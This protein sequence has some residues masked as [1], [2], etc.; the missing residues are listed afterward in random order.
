MRPP[1]HTQWSDALLDAQRQVGDPPADAVVDALFAGGATVA[2]AAN[3]LLRDLVDN[4]DIPD[5]ALPAQVRDYFLADRLPPWADHDAIDLAGR[6]FHREAPRLVLLLHTAALPYCYAARRGVQV[7]ARTDRIGSDTQ[8]RILET[9]QFV[10]DV[11]APGGLRRDPD[12]FGAGV[13]SAQKVRLMHAAIRR[14]L[15]LDPTW[16]PEWGV[17]I[18]QEDLA[19]TLLSFSA[20][21]LRGLQGLG[22]DLSDDE[23]AAYLHAWNV[24]GAL[25]GV[26]PA[27]MAPDYP[28]ALRLTDAIARRHHESCPEGQAMTRALLR[29]MEYNLPGT[30]LDGLPALLLHECAGPRVAALLGVERPALHGRWVAA[31]RAMGRLGDDLRDQ[32]ALLR[33]AAELTGRLTLQGLLLAYRGPKRAPFRLPHALREA[34]GLL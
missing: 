10:L 23:I 3:V 15:R 27:L 14:F 33:R 30:A 25:L 22:V 21:S 29:Y 32:S 12:R 16:D 9:A 28:A 34:H 5:A 7:L 24:V 19:G 17:P 1:T 2:Y 20:L 18:N 31:L 26:D 8:R 6:L 11:L 4:D 13:R